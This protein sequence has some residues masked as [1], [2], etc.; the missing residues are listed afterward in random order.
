MWK[1]LLNFQNAP[2]ALAYNQTVILIQN[3][4]GPHG[5]NTPTRVLGQKVTS[6]RLF[7][8]VPPSNKSMQ[9]A[10]PK[11]PI[12]ATANHILRSG[13]HLYPQQLKSHVL[14]LSPSCP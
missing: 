1:G 14:L 12:V 6:T 4:G 5:L 3:L 10:Y 2:N 8:K 7:M 11:I 9:K 13:D